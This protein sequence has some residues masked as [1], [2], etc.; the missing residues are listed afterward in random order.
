MEESW[1]TFYQAGIQLADPAQST[2]KSMNLTRP[3]PA[4]VEDA[5]L[6][7]QECKQDRT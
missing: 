2:E 1:I 7:P 4:V 3:L 5:V 6:D